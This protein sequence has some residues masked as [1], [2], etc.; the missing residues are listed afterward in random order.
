MDPGNRRIGL[1][2][3]DISQTIARPLDVIQGEQALFAGLPELVEREEVTKIVIGLPLSLDGSI[4]PKAREVLKFRERV[5]K[6]LAAL[7]EPFQNVQVESWDERLT[8]VQAEVALRSGDLSARK[9]RAR[10]DKVAAQILLQC[11][12][13][14]QATRARER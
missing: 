1:A 3:S 9:R 8:S 12:L 5:E 10:V 2:L 6:F 7:E 4:G 14:C 13:D 11:Y